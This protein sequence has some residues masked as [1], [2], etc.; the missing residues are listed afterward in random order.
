MRCLLIFFGF[1]LSAALPMAAQAES[2][3]KTD[4]LYQTAL[5]LDLKLFAAYN[6]CDLATLGSL[7][8]DNLE[9]YHDQAGQM[10]GKA[11]F[12]TAIESYVCHKTRRSLDETHFQ[13]YPLANYGFVETGVHY[14]CNLQETPDCRPED[15]GEGKFFMLWQKQGDSYRLTRVISY[16]HVSSWQ[17]KP[18]PQ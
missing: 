3:A 8:D 14:F 12:L 2:T 5:S 6:D 17:R 15:L 7:V 10:V 4:P 13:V 9:F 1:L 11:P 18:K 16:D